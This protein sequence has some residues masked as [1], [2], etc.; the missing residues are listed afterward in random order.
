M[1]CYP[2]KRTPTKQA[3]VVRSVELT[4]RECLDKVAPKTLVNIALA[5]SQALGCGIT[6]WAFVQPSKY[7]NCNVPHHLTSWLANAEQALRG[8]PLACKTWNWKGWSCLLCQNQVI[9]TVA[10]ALAFCIFC[11]GICIILMVMKSK[12]FGPQTSIIKC[13]LAFT[14]IPPFCSMQSHCKVCWKI[15]ERT[16]P[17]I[18]HLNSIIWL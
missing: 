10:C 12:N 7:S 8:Q 6:Q 3:V 14:H 18:A 15:T 13:C 4:F 2:S 1:M 5:N 17:K 11:F 16:F 9:Q